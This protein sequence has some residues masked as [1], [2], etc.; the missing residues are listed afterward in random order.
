[1]TSEH[2]IQSAIM[3]HIRRIAPDV[4]AY[5]I[6]NGGG[7]SLTEGRK[8][9]AEG[10]RAGVPDLGL[11]LPDGRAAFI[12]VKKADGR[13]GGLQAG[14]RDLCARRGV[15]WAL[16]RCVEDVEQAFHAWGVKTK[17]TTL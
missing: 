4:F 6:P 11:I 14:F 1:M 10:V 9:K 5:A 2:K 3:T 12:E 7:R 13:L 16:A 17:G 15:P 8:L